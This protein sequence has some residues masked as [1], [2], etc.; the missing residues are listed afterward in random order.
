MLKWMLVLVPIVILMEFVA[1]E[2]HL[3]VFLAAALAIVPL[4]GWS[5]VQ[6]ALFV[7]PV[8]ILGLAYFFTPDVTLS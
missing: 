7:A 3:L 4:A 2:H 8:L 5:S 6:V 1:A